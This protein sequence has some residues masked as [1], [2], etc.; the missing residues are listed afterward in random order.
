MIFFYKYELMQMI[1]ALKAPCRD[2]NYY[3]Y[4]CI[5]EFLP[6]ETSF[7]KCCIQMLA[8]VLISVI[9]IIERVPGIFKTGLCHALHPR[10]AIFRT[11][12]FSSLSRIYLSVFS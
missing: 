7:L 6:L 2:Y 8:L 11:T 5:S 4:V 3:P 12:I 9:D 1:I 10:T